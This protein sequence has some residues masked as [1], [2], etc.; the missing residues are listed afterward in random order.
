M[1]GVAADAERAAAT[2][3]ALAPLLAGRDRVRISRDGG[4]NY[5]RRWERAL[6]ETLPHQ[7]AAVP[8]YTA[9]GECRVIVIDL[10][11]SRGGIPAVHR[12]ADTTTEL[13]HRCGG[14][15]IRDHSPNGGVHLYI[16]L[17]TPIGF[18]DARN[19]ALALATRLPTMDPTPNHNLTDGLIR[20]P[21]SRHRTGG[22]QTLEGSLDT[23]QR[24]AR[25]G[26]SQRVLT[27]LRH[28]LGHELDHLARRLNQGAVTEVT[29]GQAEDPRRPL[30]GR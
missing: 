1:N 30:T 25:A 8:L 6:S 17:A 29:T 11:S 9:T 20:P 28:E 24:L 2:W 21:G 27:A 13:V 12:D 14:Q 15:L 23:A 7:P 22:F 3:R 10:D 26:N 16:P 4:R 5:H 19:L 18:H